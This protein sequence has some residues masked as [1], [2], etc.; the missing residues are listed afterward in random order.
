[1]NK[2]RILQERKERAKIIVAEASNLNC[3]VLFS[4]TTCPFCLIKFAS[5]QSLKRHIGRKHA[6]NEA[7]NIRKYETPDLPFS[8]HICAK[9]FASAASLTYHKKRHDGDRPFA[10]EI[11]GKT[12]PIPS[13]LRKHVRRVHENICFIGHSSRILNENLP[14]CKT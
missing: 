9:R 1:M 7:N 2:Q 11:C 13:E 6:D 5:M 4:D 3:S 8:C 12:Y 10:C 14:I